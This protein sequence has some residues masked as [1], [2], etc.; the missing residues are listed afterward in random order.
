MV[1][2]GISLGAQTW[3][4]LEEF[5]E[6]SPTIVRGNQNYLEVMSLLSLLPIL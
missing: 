3:E 1:I 4:H 6:L 2:T 5:E